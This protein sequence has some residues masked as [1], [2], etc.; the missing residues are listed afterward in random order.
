LQLIG[1]GNEHLRIDVSWLGAELKSVIGRDGFNW[2][3]HGDTAVWNGR[4]PL[5]FPVIGKSVDGHVDIDGKLYPMPPHGV[6]RINSFALASKSDASCRLTLSDST[7]TRVSY[8]FAFE[9]DVTYTL[10]GKTLRTVAEIRNRD[11]KPMPF[12]FGFHPALMLKPAGGTPVVALEGNR[13]PDYQRLDKDGLLM[14][15]RHTSPFRDGVLTVQPHLFC[16]NALIFSQA[17]ERAWYG[18]AGQSGVAFEFPDCPYLGIWTKP[19][20]P[21]LC[22][23]PWTGLPAAPDQRALPSRAGTTMLAPGGSS[24]VAMSM[25]FGIRREDALRD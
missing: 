23:E 19:G 25:I 21:Y 24:R 14:A 11:E 1:I 12:T 5:L 9:L 15:T 8:P 7:Q 18:V 20:A 16:D 6:A 3:W 10:S 22:I 17:G 13:V 4:A 2:L